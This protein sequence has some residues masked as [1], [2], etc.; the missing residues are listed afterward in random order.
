MLAKVTAAR[1]REAIRSYEIS[2]C[3]PTIEEPW[4]G[5]YCTCSRRMTW[6]WAVRE[7]YEQERA[8]ESCV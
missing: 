3:V 7:V 2:P 6:E 8:A 5:E 1:L 4:H